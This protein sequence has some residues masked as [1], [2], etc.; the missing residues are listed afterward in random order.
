[1]PRM[2]VYGMRVEKRSTSDHEPIVLNPHDRSR[3]T[4]E[5][6]HASTLG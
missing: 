6:D 2:T 3:D 5:S 4:T 1:M